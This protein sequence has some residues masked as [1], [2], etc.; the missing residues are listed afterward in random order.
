MTT[1]AHG[2]PEHPAIEYPKSDYK[3][4]PKTLAPD[5]FWGQVRRTIYGRRITEEEVAVM[6][7][8]IRS[9]LDLHPEDDVLDLACGNGALSSRL[10]AHC[11][12][13]VGV[14]NS[15]YLIEVAHAN[16][17]DRDRSRFVLDDAAHYVESEPEPEQ[18]TKALCYGSFSFFTAE[19]AQ[20]VVTGL[21]RRFVNVSRVFL[22]NLPDRD[23]ASAFFPEGVDYAA[24]LD[25]PASQAGIWRS[26]SHLHEMAAAAGWSSRVVMMP[27]GFFNSHY[28]FDLVLERARPGS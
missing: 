16:F 14:D 9:G 20:A 4:Y 2:G 22:G 24:D 15:E 25:D 21:G 6:V 26:A 17:E 27:A 10:Y 28:R 18:F 7:D 3:E 12:S 23:R 11:R 19:S 8:A 1:S 5:D 13:L